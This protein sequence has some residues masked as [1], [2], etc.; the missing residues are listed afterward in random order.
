MTDI[1]DLRK[2]AK[3]VFLVIEE[4]I[5]EDLSNKLNDAADTIE[6]LQDL[7]IWMA[8]CGYDFSR[9]DFFCEKREKLLEV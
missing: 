7:V 4:S 8:D 9:H 5:A 1:K 2:A 3:V 6:E